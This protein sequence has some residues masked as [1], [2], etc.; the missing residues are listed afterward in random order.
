M[1]RDYLSIL[2]NM[3]S[4]SGGVG[5]SVIVERTAI[6]RYKVRKMMKELVHLNFVYRKGNVFFRNEYGTAI[7]IADNDAW[8]DYIMENV[9]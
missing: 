1:L 6:S 4:D 3:H 2:G 9:K 7:V 5:L 8:G